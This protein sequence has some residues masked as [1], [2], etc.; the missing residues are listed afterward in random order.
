MTQGKQKAA[1][2]DAKKKKAA[3]ALKVKS[4]NKKPMPRKRVS[5]VNKAKSKHINKSIENIMAERLADREHRGL[6]VVSKDPTFVSKEKQKRLKLEAKREK[7]RQEE[8]E[9]AAAAKKAA[10]TKSE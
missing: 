4:P 6:S 3:K 2:G 5:A 9:Q 7:K 10:A 8:K 1:G